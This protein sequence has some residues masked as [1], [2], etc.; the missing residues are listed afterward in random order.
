MNSF[1]DWIPGCKEGGREGFKWLSTFQR[2]EALGWHRSR[3]L[4]RLP[5]RNG[6]W[7]NQLMRCP[8]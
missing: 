7:T 6:S 5:V 1:T 2:A 4:L 3:A 8:T